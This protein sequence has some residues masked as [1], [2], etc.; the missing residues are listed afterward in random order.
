VP[1]W[2]VFAALLV[3]GA[4]TT[5]QSKQF[6]PPERVRLTDG[7]EAVEAGTV[8]AEDG[9]VRIEMRE[10]FFHPTIVTAPPGSAL[11]VTLVNAG[12]NVHNFEIASEGID[13]TLAEGDRE[14]V[15]VRVPASGG[16][17]FACKFHLP[18][19]MRGEVRAA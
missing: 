6:S 13:L 18:R 15:E 11:T 12:E 14:T 8:A 2:T 16:L 5:P 7:S 1:R 19:A 4:C 9:A 3:L 17:T 10:F